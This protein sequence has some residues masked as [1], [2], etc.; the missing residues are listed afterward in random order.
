MLGS[1]QKGFIDLAGAVIDL[2]SSPVQGLE[3]LLRIHSPTKCIPFDIAVETRDEALEWLSILREIAQ[4]ANF[5]ESR[6]KRMERTWRIAKE[7]SNLTVYCH[8][9]A[10]NLEKAK[11]DLEQNN[12][13]LYEMSSFSE[14]KAEKLLCQQ[15]SRF[16]MRYHQ[17]QFSRV[18]PKGQRIDSSNYNPISMWNVGCQMTALNFQTADKPMQLNWSKFRDN[19]NCGYLL[20]PDFMFDNKM[21]FDPNDKVLNNMLNLGLRLQL[22]II[23]ARH[24]YKSHK[25]VISPFVEVEVNGIEADSAVKLTTKIIRKFFFFRAN[26]VF[27]LF[28]EYF[29]IFTSQFVIK[30]R[31]THWCQFS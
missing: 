3:W 31:K 19:G 25:S 23:G 1:L 21:L 12:Y 20:K 30:T 8:S 16:F 11:L 14:T 9:V 29:H 10:F 6:N 4:N 22:K 26:G 28:I 27:Q 13:S 15:E 24:L 2:L 5:R 18:Y 17:N 7:I